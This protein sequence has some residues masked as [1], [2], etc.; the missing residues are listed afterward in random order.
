MGKD[1]DGYTGRQD[2]ISDA[3]Y[4]VQGEIRTHVKE[5]MNINS[6]I[7]DDWYLLRFCR[8]RKFKIA[9][10]IVM[11]EKMIAWRA[12]LKV[13]DLL[14]NWEQH[15]EASN[16]QK[17]YSQTCY[18][19]IAK[20]GRPVRI[21][22]WSEWQGKLLSTNMTPEESGQLQ[23]M[24]SEKVMRGV[25]PYC[26]M[27]AGKRID[28]DI[29]IHDFNDFGVGILW[30]KSV[31]NFVSQCAGIAQDNFPEMLGVIF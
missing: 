2:S 8:A 1:K 21:D 5:N 24:D 10:V 16:R 28:N 14:T 22:R 3:Q 11:F 23:G 25:F 19:C 20:D 6:E 18:F 29:C 7:Y 13:D 4:K 12:G 31:R 17:S 30:E 27:L 15:E 9:D 26:S